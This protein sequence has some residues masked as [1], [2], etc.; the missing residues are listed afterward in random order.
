M[1]D[2]VQDL[3]KMATDISDNPY[4]SLDYLVIESASDEIERLRKR[5]ASTEAAM[6][7]Y[8]KCLSA[9]STE[10][11]YSMSREWNDGQPADVPDHDIP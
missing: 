2:M 9:A 1:G 8:I 5:L 11:W 10:L 7:A 3:R 4:T 6:D